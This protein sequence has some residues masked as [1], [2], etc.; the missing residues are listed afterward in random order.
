MFSRRLVWQLLA[1]FL[2]TVAVRGEEQNGWPLVVRQSPPDAPVESRQYL[3]PVIFS[4]QAVGEVRGVRPLYLHAVVEG[5]ESTAFLYPFFTWERQPGYRTFSFFQLVNLRHRDEPGQ[6]G[7]KSFDVWPF[8]FSKETGDPATTYHALFPIAGTLKYRF[9]KDAL[10]WY[11]F[12]LYLHSEKSG[13]EVTTAPWPFLTFI[14]GAGHHGFEF[15]PLFGHRGR[16][17]DYDRQ[18]YLWPLIYYSAQHLDEPVPTVH[19]GVL[20]FYTRDTGPGLNSETYVWPF[21]GYTHRVKPDRYYE[22]RYFWPLFVQ[23]VGESRQINRWAPFYTHSIIKGYEKTWVAWP[24]Y[25]H[26]EWAD[27]KIAQ[28]RNQ[29]LYFVYWSQ[30]QRSLTNPAAAPAHK[31]HLWPLYS[32]WDNGAGRRQLQVLSPFE[33]FFPNN[34]VIRQLYTPLFALYRYDRQDDNTERR[35][36]LWNAITWRHSATDRAFHLGPLFSVQTG[37]DHQRVAFGAGLF[38]W[39]RQPG[40]NHARFFLFDFAR[41]NANKTPAMPPP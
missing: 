21:F 20:P 1:V 2:A 6:P 10:T 40:E 4:K 31:A 12:P 5:K 15:W 26:A 7:E 11:V 8:Y 34:D 17:N 39:Q 33:I 36:L 22:R 3:G 13:M 16:A 25:R 29:F 32:S 35:S 24:F 27:D 23:G 28:E 19:R 30:T 9:G 18:F 41:K 37:P 14:S 38:G